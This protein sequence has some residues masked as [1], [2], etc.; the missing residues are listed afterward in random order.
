MNID[1]L[2]EFCC[3]FDPNG[4]EFI[5]CEKNSYGN[6]NFC[7]EHQDKINYLTNY[8]TIENNYC[9]AKIKNLLT[10]YEKLNS[11]QEK[12][13]MFDKIYDLLYKHKPFLFK[14]EKLNNTVYLKLLEVEED[15]PDSKKYIHLIYPECCEC[16]KKN[17]TKINKTKK[18]DI[19]DE[20]NL[21]III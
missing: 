3:Y 19:I 17:T 14:N 7:L 5:P 15:Y 20:D 8:Q 1:K 6:T 21:T 9:Q 18:S 12:I 11:K 4:D 10:N 2:Y 16:C 13:N